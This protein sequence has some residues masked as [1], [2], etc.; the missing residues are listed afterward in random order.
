M[1]ALVRA[2]R[3]TNLQRLNLRGNPLNSDPVA[4]SLLRDRFGTQLRELAL[5]RTPATEAFVPPTNWYALY[6]S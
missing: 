6:S 2:P 3:L 4:I 5:T 1:T